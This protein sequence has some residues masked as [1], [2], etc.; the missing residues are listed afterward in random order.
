MKYCCFIKD[1]RKYIGEY[2]EKM[3]LGLDDKIIN[4]NLF[5]DFNIYKG[6]P[7][8]INDIRLESALPRNKMVYGIADNFKEDNFPL[9]FFKSS[10]NS[11]L[12]M[13]KNFDLI[14]NSN[15]EKIWAETELGFVISKDI[16]YKTNEIIDK[17]YIL[18]YFLANDLTGSIRNQDHHLICSKSCP[19]FLQIGDFIDT[20][21]KPRFQKILLIQDDIKLREDQ[22][23]KRNYDEISILKYLSKFFNLKKGDSILTG[24][25]KR[26]RDR[27]YLNK[28]HNLKLEIEGL[29]KKD[30]SINIIK[31]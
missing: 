3:I 31:N 19:G 16:N 10:S 28:R 9:V 18:G 2:S 7:L 15:I 14:I 12:V 5:A 13:K 8:F 30:I 26:C 4:Y 1:S 6:E 25:P 20:S 29:E 11:S 21:F 23:D 22:I 27:M 24:A 17:S